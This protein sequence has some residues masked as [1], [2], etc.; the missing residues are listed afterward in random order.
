[1][2][3][4]LPWVQSLH[5]TR[6]DSSLRGD[7][8]ARLLEAAARA[9]GHSRDVEV[10][11]RDVLEGHGKVL[12]ERVLCGGALEGVNRTVANTRHHTHTGIPGNQ[13]CMR[14]PAAVTFRPS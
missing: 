2:L 8:P 13:R 3:L 5:Q 9:R 7:V 1:M 10:L 11:D 12:G 14:M 4:I 6:G